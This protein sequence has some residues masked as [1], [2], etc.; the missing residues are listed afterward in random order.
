MARKSTYYS[1]AKFGWPVLAAGVVIMIYSGQAESVVS[2]SQL[3]RGSF[4]LFGVAVGAVIAGWIFIGYLETRSW[5]MAGRW[6][7]LKSASPSSLLGKPDLTDTINGRTVRARIVKR[8]VKRR[9][10][11]Q[12]QRFTVVE[13]DLNTPAEE[14]LIISTVRGGRTRGTSTQIEINP[15]QAD[16]KD[17]KL[18]VVGGS[19]STAQSVISGRSRH[20]LLGMDEFEFVFVGDAKEAIAESTPDMSDSRLASFLQNKAAEKIP[21]DAQKV[22][23]ETKGLLLDGDRLRQ[24]AEAVATVADAF[25]ET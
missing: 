23:I 13:A 19:E 18:V 21:G 22:T 14:G 9:E 16:V 4:G 5:Q 2:A 10:S 1:A 24:Q 6:A 12:Q 11:S 3:P 15:E 7:N 20:A 17:D 8:K 25:E